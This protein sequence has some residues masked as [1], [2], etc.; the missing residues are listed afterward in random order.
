MDKLTR[1]QFNAGDLVIEENQMSRK[2]FILRKGKVRVFKNYLNRKVVL[3]ILKPGEI[4]G[5][6][7]FF[8]AK[9][10][11]ASVEALE[12][13]V[14]DYIDG[15]NLSQEIEELPPWTRLIFVSIAKRFREVDQKLTVYESMVGFKKKTLAASDSAKTIYQDLG[16][17][18]KLTEMVIKEEAN[19]QS[20]EKLETKLNELAGQSFVNPAAFINILQEY[21]F[22]EGGGFSSSKIFTLKE[23]KLS[24]FSKFVSEKLDQGD[25]LILSHPALSI[26]RKIM[27]YMSASLGMGAGLKWIPEDT[28]NL[29]KVDEETKD[30]LSE[31]SK[32]KLLELK[33]GEI[34]IN[35]KEL[36]KNYEFLSI[37][38]AFDRAELN[39]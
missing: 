22:S 37:V 28:F 21:D 1:K 26:L 16:K 33:Y 12:D 19:Y 14:V 15:K 30:G 36:A 5:E 31:L 7:S 34:G 17:L 10:R 4:F 32:A 27:S 8:D 20:R 3:A 39:D 2:L 24:E 9:P 35:P 23:D 18:L 29:G 25:F 11:S 6:L 38:K 13:I